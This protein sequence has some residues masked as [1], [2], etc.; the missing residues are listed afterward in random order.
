M[1]PKFSPVFQ[2][3]ESQHQQAKELFLSLGK[4]IKS[5]KAIELAT[6]L[7]FLEVYSDLLNKIHFEVKG[8]NFDLFSQFKSLQKSLH[9]IH[10]FKLVEKSLDER[11]LT[12]NIT[13]GSYRKHL[14]EYKK[15]L[16]TQAFDLI[17][18]SPLKN[19]DDLFEKAKQYSQAIKPLSINTA[20]NQIIEEELDYFAMDSKGPMDTKLLKDTFIGLRI[21]VMLENMR[22]HLGFNP[23]FVPK[24]HLEIEELKNNL[25]PWY[26]NHLNYQSLTYFASD[27]DDLSKKYMDWLKD[28]K[29]EKK[30]LSALSEKRAQKL[31][32]KILG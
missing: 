11:E 23:I 3:F 30:V 20:I 17:V 4:Q 28:L 22:V 31:F 24:V 7:D 25:K 26:V 5:K 14:D 9:K 21:L 8:L 32:E 18:G 2:I 6:K 15:D 1:L 27:K 10:H 29:A 19:W 16:Y 12:Q 13:Y